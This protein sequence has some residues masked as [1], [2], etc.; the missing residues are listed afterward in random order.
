M[1]I[2]RYL[3]FVAFFSVAGLTVGQSTKKTPATS[4]T[5][6]TPATKKTNGVPTKKTATPTAATKKT[7][8]SSSPSRATFVTTDKMSYLYSEPINIE[9]HTENPTSDD[10]IG[11]YDCVTDEY[12][13]DLYTCG[14]ETCAEGTASGS[15]TFKTNLVVGCYVA[16][17]Q[18]ADEELIAQSNNFDVVTDPNTFITTDKLNYVNAAQVEVT[19]GNSFPEESDWIGV[20]L[21]DYTDGDEPQWQSTNGAS[22]GTLMF[23]PFDS[24]CYNAYLLDSL[25]QTIVKSSDFTVSLSATI[26]TD[27]TSY[28][29]GDTVIVTYEYANPQVDDYV[30]IYTC[31]TSENVDWAYTDGASNTVSFDSLE[32]GCYLASIVDANDLEIVSSPQFVIEAASVTTDKTSYSVGETVIVSFDY[33]NPQEDDYVAIYACSTFT[34]VTDA[35]TDGNSPST[36]SFDSLEVGCYVASLYNVNDIELAYSLDFNVVANLS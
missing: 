36:V 1:K 14:Q 3:V 5:K 29:L 13:D 12:W 9:F 24:G 11:I 2:G 23:G 20:Y 35:Y 28:S 21:C 4:S 27:K 30:G 25:D 22:A 34:F 31:D 16:Y 26:T 7:S 17:L 33:P 10:W 19:F 8:P 15:L 18:D 6:K 32:G